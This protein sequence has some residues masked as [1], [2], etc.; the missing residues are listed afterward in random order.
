[1]RCVISFLLVLFLLVMSI[2]VLFGVISWMCLSSICDLG[3]LNV[4]VFVW[5]VIV[6]EV[7][8]GKLKMVM[9]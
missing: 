5:I 3:L 7:G 8:F 6:C 9:V 1:M 4:S 2:V